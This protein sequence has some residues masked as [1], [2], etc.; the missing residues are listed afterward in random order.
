MYCH[1]PRS[2]TQSIIFLEAQESFHI[3]LSLVVAFKLGCEMFYTLIKSKPLPRPTKSTCR[4]NHFVFLQKRWET[5]MTK[6]EDTYVESASFLHH[7]FLT[8]S[9]LD[10]SRQTTYPSLIL[11]VQ[12]RGTAQQIVALAAKPN[13]LSSISPGPTWCKERVNFLKLS[14]DLQVYAGCAGALVTEP[15]SK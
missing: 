4:Q 11:S 13:K 10:R 14:S 7:L 8:A 12:A 1:L 6:A 3:F 2:Y 9:G 5:P 15:A